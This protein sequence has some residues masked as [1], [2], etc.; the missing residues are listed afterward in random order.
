MLKVGVEVDNASLADAVALFE[1]LGGNSKEATRKAVNKAAR[2]IRIVSR[3]E[4]RKDLRLTS[5]YV[6]ERLKVK[7]AKRGQ[8]SASIET[9][10]RGLRLAHFSTDSE[11]ATERVSW[12]KV[13]ESAKSSKSKPKIFSV[14]IKPGGP[15]QPVHGKPGKSKPFFIVGKNSRALIMVQRRNNGSLDALYGPSLSQA[16]ER[17][18]ERVLPDAK[19]ELEKQMIAAMNTILKKQHPTETEPGVEL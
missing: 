15:V 10:S 18:R 12:I 5:S 9:P 11:I 17:V 16:F 13:P 7:A 2:R 4:I 8:V 3:R 14:Q 19:A 1:F 6:S